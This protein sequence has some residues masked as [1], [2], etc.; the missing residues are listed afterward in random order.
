MRANPGLFAERCLEQVYLFWSGYSKPA[1]S[2]RWLR[3]AGWIVFM[4]LASVGVA[5][6]SEAA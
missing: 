5:L 1:D 6:R 2:Q 3:A 4:P